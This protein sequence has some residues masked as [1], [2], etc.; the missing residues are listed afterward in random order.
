MP[1]LGPLFQA[2]NLITDIIN[3]FRSRPEKPNV[4]DQEIDEAMG[5]ALD[6]S[7]PIDEVIGAVVDGSEEFII[8]R[9]TREGELTPDNIEEITDDV[10]GNAATLLATIYGVGLAVEAGSLG[11]VDTQGEYLVQALA[12]LGVDDVTGMELEARVSEGV[13]PALEQDVNREH[14]AKK[15]NFQDWVEFQLRNKDSDEGWLEFRGID[16]LRPDQQEHLERA[17]LKNLEPEELIE[18]PVEAGIIPDEETLQNQLDIA[19]LPE[20]TKDLFLEVRDNLDQTTRI[21]EERTVAEELVTQLDDAV[22]AG[23]ITAAEAGEL[24]PGEIEEARDSLIARWRF[25]EEL[26]QQSPSESDIIQMLTG[27]YRSLSETRERLERGFLDTEKYEDLLRDEVRKD[28]D[29]DLQEAVALGIMSEGRFSDLAEFAGLDDQAIEQLLQGRSY[30]DITEQRLA[31][32]TSPS[33]RSVRTIIGIGEARG[34][35]LQA[36]GIE[37]VQ[38]LANASQEDVAEAAQV[39]PETAQDFIDAAAR[40]V[41][42]S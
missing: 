27:G 20:D 41:S 36:S 37:T 19:G 26:P 21:Y 15:S 34:S 29:G 3:D 31:E 13:M 8:Q 17:A 24:V 32:E 2:F 7:Q 9:L 4:Q 1:L 28:L 5:A 40:R 11:Q 39:S 12:G 6:E 30:S 38:D 25:L 18:T 22:R 23:E 42:S 14:R 33:E 35:A 16:G 10:E